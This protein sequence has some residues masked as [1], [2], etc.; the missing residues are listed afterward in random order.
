MPQLGPGET[1]A[2]YPAE[3]P[4]HAV[5]AGEQAPA[6]RRATEAEAASG[7]RTSSIISSATQPSGGRMGH[8]EAGLGD[9]LH[10]SSNFCMRLES[11][12]Y[13]SSSAVTRHLLFTALPDIRCPPSPVPRS[14]PASF[15][16]TLGELASR[17][18]T[19]HQSLLRLIMNSRLWCRQRAFVIPASTR[20]GAQREA[21]RGCPL[22]TTCGASTTW[23]QLKR[24]SS[25]RQSLVVGS[26][27]LH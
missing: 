20:V 23:R 27:T 6:F 24:S 5:I 16:K 26:M 11:M 22:G 17:S 25:C 21:F 15:Q 14:S 4:S 19:N 9:C 13:S 2:P 3:L 18:S 7:R 12:G 8:H 1:Y 10:L